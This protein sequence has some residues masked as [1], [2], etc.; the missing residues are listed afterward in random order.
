[1]ISPSP[2]AQTNPNLPPGLLEP[3]LPLPPLPTTPPETPT[4]S[5]PLAPPPETPQNLPAELDVK[6]T[7]KEIEIL[8]STAFSPAELQTAVSSFIGQEATFEELLA[9]RTAITQLYIDNGYTTSGAFLPSQDL[10]DG[11]VR[12]QVVEGGIERIDIQGLRRLRPDYVRD[13]IGLAAQAP[14]NL[15]RLE[16]ALQL[17]QLDPLLDTV[18]AELSAGTAPGFSVLQ[19][20]VTEAQPLSLAVIG[21]NR[22]SPSVGSLGGTVTIAHNNLLGFGDR[23]SVDYGLT[24]GINSYNFSYQI[25]LNPHDGTLSLSYGRS[26]SD[27]IEEP[28]S[29]LDINARTS[30]FSVGF[31]QPI[32]RTPSSEFALSLSL[33]LH[34]SETFLLEDIPFSFS[35]GPEKGKSR[36]TALRF[37]QDWTNRSATRVLAARSQ[38]SFGLD[39]LNS[40]INENGIDGRFMSWVGQFQWVQALGGDAIFIARAGAQL[41]NDSL[42]S[43]EQFS[44]GGIDTVRGYR[45]NQRV[46]DNGIVGSLEFRLPI[47]QQPE[48][49]GT[50]QLAPFFDIG[51]VWNNEDVTPNP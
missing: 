22:D 17:L 36:V 38:F 7:V 14:V 47:V 41:S 28:F 24:Q 11:V 15:R 1:P 44:I 20:N 21:E 3:N 26:R 50:I 42:L 29:R 39:A 25:P 30:T 31:R 32:V 13:R 5:R 23:L 48:G 37:T 16:E 45:Q 51:T 34:Q 6:V 8:G 46:A 10:T 18:Q 33:D 4:P 27:I 9:I 35:L 19:L 12:I 2:L 43:L 40:T 49:I